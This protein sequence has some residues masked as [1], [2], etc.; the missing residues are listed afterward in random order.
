MPLFDNILA[1]VEEADR[2]VL[3]KNPMVAQEVNRLDGL[4]SSWEE[5]RRDH[6]DDSNKMTKNAVEALKA[7]DQEIEALKLMQEAEVDWESLKGS[8]KSQQ[9]DLL[10]SRGV[11]TKDSFEKDILPKLTMAKPD[12]IKKVQDKV[13]NL[14]RGMEFTYAKTAHLPFE[15]Y[16]EFSSLNDAPKFTMENFFKHMTDNKFTDIDRAYENMVQPLRAKLQEEATAKREAQIR[17]E[18]RDETVKEFTM[19]QGRMPI[20]DEGSSPETS[21]LQMRIKAHKKIEDEGA[22]KLTPGSLGDGTAG[23]DAYQ[24]WLRDKANGKTLVQ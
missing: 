11:L 19:K 20:D 4:V 13:D 23:N 2:E 22:P 18:S 3:K 9:E 12:D 5:W 24:G 15:Y 21:A 17:K 16:R 6:W 10:N 8:I 7:K 1:M 14:E